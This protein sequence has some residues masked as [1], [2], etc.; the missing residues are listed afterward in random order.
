MY[1]LKLFPRYVEIL[2][3]FNNRESIQFWRENFFS[4]IYFITRDSKYSV[5]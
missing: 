1:F 3:K 4:K 5:R 2:V